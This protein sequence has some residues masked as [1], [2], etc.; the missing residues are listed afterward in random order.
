M[1]F[2]R[3]DALAVIADGLGWIKMSCEQRGLLKLFDNNVV[4]QRFFCQLLNATFDLDLKVMDDVRTNYPAIDLGDSTNRI[5][6]QITTEKRSDKVQSTLQKFVQHGLDKQYDTLKILVIGDRQ[7]TYDAVEVPH[8]LKFDCDE[9]ILDIQGLFKQIDPLDTA[10]LEKLRAIFEHE[11]KYRSTSVLAAHGVQ[12]AGLSIDIGVDRDGFVNVR[13]GE[14]YPTERM[15]RYAS[16]KQV[17]GDEERLVIKPDLGYL[18]MLESGAPVEAIKFFHNPFLCQF[19]NLDVTF[20]NNTGETLAVTGAVFEVAESVQDMRP[21]ILFKDDNVRMM[22]AITNEGWGTVRNAVLKCNILPTGAEEIRPDP[23]IRHLSVAGPY[24]HEFAIGDFED[25]Y[26]LNLEPTFVGLG[27]DIAAIKAAGF[28][29]QQMYVLHAMQNG[30]DTELWQHFGRFPNLETNDTWKAFPDGYA[31]VAGVLEYDEES[32]RGVTTRRSLPFRV[33]VFMFKIKY[34]LPMPPSYQY[35]LSLEPDGKKYEV[36]CPVSQSLKVGEADRIRIYVACER[37]ATHTFRIK[38]LLNG[39]KEAISEPIVL[40]HFVPRTWSAQ[41]KTRC[42]AGPPQ[43]ASAERPQVPGSD[44]GCVEASIM[45][46][47][48]ILAARQRFEDETKRQSPPP[49][50]QPANQ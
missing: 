47:M 6:Y 46:A 34:S 28:R 37:S 2:K 27:V 15:L 30:L 18:S 14:S 5:A 49:G 23:P 11:M 35:N 48:A 1:V 13:T 16:T 40:K 50:D 24:A 32:G 33:R 10:H 39:G 8:G 7:A 17:C 9:D 3:T 36:F 19:P 42:E 43:D 29:S 26:E 21:L 22:L 25:H 38:W 31:V 12:L 41:R 20:V 45:N 44:V 4:A